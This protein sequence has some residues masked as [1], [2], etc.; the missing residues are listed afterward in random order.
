MRMTQVTY[1]VRTF[2]PPC[3]EGHRTRLDMG[4]ELVEGHIVSWTG[5]SGQEYTYFNN[6]NYPD[7][8][9]NYVFAKYEKRGLDPLDWNK[10]LFEWI[11][12]YVGETNDLKQRLAN[13]DRF[14][15]L[16]WECAVSLGAT[17]IFTHA[18]EGNRRREIRDLDNRYYL[19]CNGR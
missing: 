17:H 16:P 14:E 18:S 9:G 10:P 4:T 15:I 8:P 6:G 2:D 7:V 19:P 13:P 3:N 5:E 12:L 1:I 11:P